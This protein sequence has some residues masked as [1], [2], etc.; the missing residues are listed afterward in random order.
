M[1]KLLIDRISKLIIHQLDHF[2]IDYDKKT[3]INTVPRAIEQMEQNFSNAASSRFYHN[4]QAVINP[5]YSVTW[6]IILYRISRILYQKGN[7][8]EAD[9]VY[10]LNKV[11]NSVDWYYGVDLPPHF[12]CEHPLGS[13]LGKATYSDYLFVYQGTTIG[14]NVNN[15][16]LFYPKIGENVVLFANS[17]VLG[18]T[19][20]GNNVI[21][22]ANTYIIN[23]VIPDNCIVFGSSPN[24]IIKDNNAKKVI[25]IT[26]R[27]WRNF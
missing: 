4:D 9:I 20:I 16:E 3:I 1:N 27:L 21:I 12:L 26:S 25:D 11:M 15:H 24:L 13:V 10:Y 14:G 22:S 19:Y 5:H 8:Q 7:I 18:L 23:E 2:W 17:T 6:A